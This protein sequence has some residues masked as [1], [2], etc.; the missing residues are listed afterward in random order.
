MEMEDD[1]LT[2]LQGEM[3]EEIEEY[4][5]SGQLVATLAIVHDT[6]SKEI[7]VSVSYASKTCEIRGE[8]SDCRS[9]GSATSPNICRLMSKT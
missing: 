3:G 5:A 4:D 8:K 6:F 1:R 9:S 2:P 7:R